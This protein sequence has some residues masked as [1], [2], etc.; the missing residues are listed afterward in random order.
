MDLMK[1]ALGMRAKGCLSVKAAVVLAG[2][3]DTWD[4]RHDQVKS[5]H[6]LSA[7]ERLAVAPNGEGMELNV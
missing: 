5:N 1:A 7:R 3:L 6:E 2:R 4:S